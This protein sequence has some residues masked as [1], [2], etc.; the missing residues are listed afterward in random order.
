MSLVSTNE[1][2]P[3]G[4]QPLRAMIGVTTKERESYDTNRA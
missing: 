4:V 3:S 1:K 2:A